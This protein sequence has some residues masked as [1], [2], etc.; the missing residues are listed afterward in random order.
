MIS[1]RLP[2]AE[3]PEE[4]GGLRV[5]IDR[6]IYM[7]DAVTPLD[8]PHAFAYFITIRND[9]TETVTIKGRKWVI[10]NDEGEMTAV[11]GDGVVGEFPRLDPGESF[12]YNS[13][14]ISNT[15]RCRAEGAYL[16]LTDDG[17]KVFTRIPRFTMEVPL[18][19]EG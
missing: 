15:R 17:R 6:V 12:S 18:E 1:M 14:H 4:L 5:H 8:C 3:T 7:V 10:T 19:G 2:Q 16:A 11:E 9:S 13:Y